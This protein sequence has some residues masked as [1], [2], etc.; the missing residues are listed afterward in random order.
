VYFSVVDAASAASAATALGGE[1]LAGPLAT[2]IG[3]MAAIRD[4][5]GAV[6]SVFQLA[7]ES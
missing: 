4:P 6:F 2:P 3:P 7:A 5:L 1:L